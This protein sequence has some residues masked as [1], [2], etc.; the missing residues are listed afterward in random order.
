MNLT[1]GTGGGASPDW[2]DDIT[3]IVMPAG[4]LA[5]QWG[6]SYGM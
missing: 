4:K 5:L 1:E 6:S 2:T 3:L